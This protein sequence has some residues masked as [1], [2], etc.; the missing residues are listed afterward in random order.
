MEAICPR[1]LFSFFPCREEPPCDISDAVYAHECK[2]GYIRPYPQFLCS[3]CKPFNED[4]KLMSMQ[5]ITKTNRA[6][7]QQRIREASE[8]KIYESELE[9]A[10]V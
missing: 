7:K 6:R 2:T 10:L 4:T 8:D 3:N 1:C 9:M 5:T